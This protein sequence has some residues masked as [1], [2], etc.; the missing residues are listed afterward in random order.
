MQHR[1]HTRVVPTKLPRHTI[2]ETPDVRAALDELRREVGEERL[3]LAEIVILGAREKVRQLR[4]D[5]ARDDALL[6]DLADRIRRREPIIDEDAADQV[7]RSGWVR[8]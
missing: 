4:D 8:P 2:T 5:R 7:R 3:A 6:S 1:C